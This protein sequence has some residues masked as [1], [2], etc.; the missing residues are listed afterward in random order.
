MTATWNGKEALEYL[1]ATSRGQNTKPDMILMDV[2]MP[3]IDGYKC[4]HLLRHHAPYKTVVQDV[5]IVAMTASAIHGDKEKCNRAGMDDYLAKP[6]TMAILEKMLIRWCLA[7]RKASFKTD[8]PSDCSQESEHCDTAGIP[9]V[10][11]DKDTSTGQNIRDESQNSL[12]TPKPLTTANGQPELSPFDSP[13]GLKVQVTRQEGEKEW[14][15]LLQENKLIDAAG[16][17]SF[18]RTPS[19]QEASPGEA[20]TEEN[21]KKLKNE[22]K[23]LDNEPTS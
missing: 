2:Q 18:H 4:T 7:G 14:S 17:P 8:E 22:T 23:N 16:G 10:G 3:V 19:F 6:V 15:S 5:P 21:M 1:A 13:A 9:A 20:L 12:L 11:L